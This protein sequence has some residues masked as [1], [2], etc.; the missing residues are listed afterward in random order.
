M[1]LDAAPIIY[2][3]EQHSTFGPRTATWLA[4]NATALVSGELARLECLV[5][6][7]RLGNA[8]RVQDFD[9]FFTTQ[10]DLLVTLTRPIY[11]RAVQIRAA[12]RRFKA[13]DALHLA[14]AVE[15]GCDAFLTNDH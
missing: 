2:L 1:Y 12:Y 10:L 3:I 15:S 6:P 8:S 7:I 13:V 11:D 4:S 9:T 14:S 5:M